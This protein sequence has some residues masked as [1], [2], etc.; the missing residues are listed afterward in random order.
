MDR[1]EHEK[2]TLVMSA[3][4]SM[5]LNANQC[6]KGH[7][8]LSID[9]DPTPFSLSSMNVAPRPAPIYTLSQVQTT[10]SGRLSIL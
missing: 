4:R 8:P 3:A 6:I 5:T 10:D 9:E 2:T 1:N 7:C